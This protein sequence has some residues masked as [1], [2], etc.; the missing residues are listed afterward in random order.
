M[1]VV[2]PAQ[3]QRFLSGLDYPSSRV[4]LIEYAVEEGADEDVIDTLTQIPD[5]LYR[6]PDDVNQA[7]EE[8]QEA[9]EEE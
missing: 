9:T 5:D 3:V 2:S 1:A 7:I 8:I 6:T 4:E